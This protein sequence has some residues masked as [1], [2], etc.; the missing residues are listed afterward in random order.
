[1]ADFQLGPLT[2]RSWASAT[3]TPSGQPQREMD[4]WEWQHPDVAHAYVVG[5][6]DDWSGEAIHAFVVPSAGREPYPDI[7][8]SLVRAELGAANLPR[9]ITVIAD[10][11]LTPGCK[12]DKNALLVNRPPAS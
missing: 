8:S 1:L 10:V 12:P 5:T 6:A 7:L 4:P 2:A 11:P 3:K 9:T